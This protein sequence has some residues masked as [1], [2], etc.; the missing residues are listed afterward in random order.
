MA[1]YINSPIYSSG[2]FRSNPVQCSPIVNYSE[3]MHCGQLK[4]TERTFFVLVCR[5]THLYTISLSESAWKCPTYFCWRYSCCPSCTRAA[6]CSG[7]TSKSSSTMSCCPCTRWCSSPSSYSAEGMSATWR[8]YLLGIMQFIAEERSLFALGGSCCIA[9]VHWFCN[10]GREFSHFYCIIKLPDTH[11]RLKV[12]FL[13]HTIWLRGC[14]YNYR[15]HDSMQIG[16]HS[17]EICSSII[18]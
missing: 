9:P 5:H 18:L 4:C 15:R 14:Y 2:F 17:W 13:S 10:R 1:T 12:E 6:L 7:T 16:Y 8:E 11:R 3:P